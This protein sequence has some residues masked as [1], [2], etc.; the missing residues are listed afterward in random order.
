VSPSPSMKPARLTKRVDALVRGITLHVLMGESLALKGVPY[1]KAS[2]LAK[3]AAVKQAG[4]DLAAARTVVR[5]KIQAREEIHAAVRPMLEPLRWLF[6]GRYG[7]EN[8]ILADF[9]IPIAGKRRKLT[10]AE[11]AIATAEGVRTR[12]AR[13][14]YTSK[15]QRRQI[16]AEGK[17]GLSFIDAQ[18]N[19][20]E[21]LPPAPPGKPRPKR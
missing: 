21:I 8:P 1:D 9:G 5:Q 7:P 11:K 19:L 16:T 15:K 6:A 18:G 14:S 2:L 17:P 3:L 20:T 4:D 13:G 12:R 10:A